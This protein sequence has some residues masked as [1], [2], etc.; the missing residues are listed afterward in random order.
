MK[1]IITIAVV[2][3][4]FVTRAFALS[5]ST[6]DEKIAT[7]FNTEYKGASNVTWIVTDEYSEAKFT[8]NGINTASLFDTD[9]ELIATSQTIKTDELPA[10]TVAAV[11]NKYK[12]YVLTQ[13]VRVEKPY[14]KDPTYYVSVVNAKRRVVLEVRGGNRMRQTE[15]TY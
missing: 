11:A 1:K 5:G 13:A 12:G 14:S 3:A 8:W 15:V 10:G 7:R 6:V 4:S 2:A 9:G